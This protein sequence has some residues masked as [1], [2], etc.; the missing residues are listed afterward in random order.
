VEAEVDG[1][2]QDEAADGGGGHG[3]AVEE[4]ELEAAEAAAEGR[5]LGSML[6]FCK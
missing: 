1:Q 5:A 3:Q 4:D 2:P 6:Q